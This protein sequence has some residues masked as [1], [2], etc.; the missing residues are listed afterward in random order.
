MHHC[1]IEPV[2]ITNINKGSCRNKQKSEFSEL[3]LQ[4][5]NM[6]KVLK[7]FVV[8]SCALLFS[9]VEAGRGEIFDVDFNG[10]IDE[11]QKNYEEDEAD[12]LVSHR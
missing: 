4:R 2:P 3:N 12:T 11:R 1:T 8:S 9:T 5:L 10:T 6:L 7:L